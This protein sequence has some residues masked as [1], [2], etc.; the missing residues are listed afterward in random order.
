MGIDLHRRLLILILIPQRN[1]AAEGET[2]PPSR[3]GLDVYVDSESLL[4]LRLELWLL[5][6]RQSNLH[7]PL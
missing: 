5:G 2:V 6:L 1:D 7:E 3:A 4:G